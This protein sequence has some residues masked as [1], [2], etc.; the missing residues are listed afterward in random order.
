MDMLPGYKPLVV[1]QPTLSKAEARIAK[2]IACTGQTNKEIAGKLFVTEKTVKFHLTNI[3]KKFGFRSRMQLKQAYM[4]KGLVYKLISTDEEIP[5][6]IKPLV[7]GI[8]TVAETVLA[9]D[10]REDLKLALN[11]L[12][13]VAQRL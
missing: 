2:F 10:V 7:R 1:P 13:D 9:P 5:T 3:Y 11:I 4:D 6:D 12:D 8:R